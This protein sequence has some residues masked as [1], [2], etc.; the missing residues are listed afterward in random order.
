MVLQKLFGWIL[1]LTGLF[2]V[3]ALPGMN[4]STPGRGGY[5]PDEFASVIIVIG[6]AI[7]GVGI[8]LLVKS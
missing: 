4:T 5:M 8:Y 2:F 3:V 1:I 6:L 7:I